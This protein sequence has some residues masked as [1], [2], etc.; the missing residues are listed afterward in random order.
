MYKEYL[1]GW[2]RAKVRD[3]EV[4]GQ[5]DAYVVEVIYKCG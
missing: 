1:A 3:G 5:W 4:W 2:R